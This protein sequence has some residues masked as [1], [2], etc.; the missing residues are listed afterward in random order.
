MPLIDASGA[1]GCG[2]LCVRVT[3]IPDGAGQR[4]A[5]AQRRAS[6]DA[7][8]SEQALQRLN[9]EGERFRK[10]FEQ[11]RRRGSGVDVLEAVAA[12]AVGASSEATLGA[13]TDSSPA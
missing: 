10:Q 4:Q 3:W 5:L 1:G 7:E 12:G 6:L 8:L 13:G 11:E 2:E 9:E